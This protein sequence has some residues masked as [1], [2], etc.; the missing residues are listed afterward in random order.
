MTVELTLFH[1]SRGKTLMGRL[2]E[3]WSEFGYF[4]ESGVSGVFKGEAGLVAMQS[5][6]RRCGTRRLRNR[7]PAGR[8][9]QGFSGRHYLKARRLLP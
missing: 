7:G 9:N 4:K 6:W 3:I 8:E 2:R 1:R 5:S